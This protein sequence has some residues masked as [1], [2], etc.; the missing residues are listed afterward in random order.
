MLLFLN[1]E[2]DS[3]QKLIESVKGDV[4]DLLNYASEKKKC[5]LSTQYV[6]NNLENVKSRLKRKWSKYSMLTAK[7]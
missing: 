5:H 1:E 2:I 3:K 6:E 7:P 4:I